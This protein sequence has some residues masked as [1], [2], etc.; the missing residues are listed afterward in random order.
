M[1]H[2]GSGEDFWTGFTGFSGF[3]GEPLA[4]CLRNERTD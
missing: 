4:K 3:T 2:A 1:K